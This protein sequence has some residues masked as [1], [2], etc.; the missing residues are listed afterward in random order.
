MTTLMNNKFKLIAIDID[1]TLRTDSNSDNSNTKSILNKC[2]QLGAKVVVATGRSYMS[3]LTY[4][5][6]VHAV[7]LYGDKG[8][9][10]ANKYGVSNEID[11]INGTLAK[12]FGQI[13]GYIAGNKEL[14]DF[15][16]SFTP[17]FIFTTSIMPSVAAASKK[18]IEIAEQSDFLRKDIHKK[19]KRTQSNNLH[20]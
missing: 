5:D 13:G 19:A 6:E 15:I 10:I 16:R 11:I 8:R 12:A 4:L 2:R 9:G 14:I 18:S 3:A 1:G 20:Y 17:G 7:G